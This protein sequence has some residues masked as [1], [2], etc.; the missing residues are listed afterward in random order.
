MSVQSDSFLSAGGLIAGFRFFGKLPFYLHRRVS[1][2]EARA[3]QANRL[4]RRSE[5][6]LHRVRRDVFDHPGSVY[7]ELFRHA[8]CEL[9][10]VEI[11]IRKDGLEDTLARLFRAGVYLT[12]DEYKGR[13]G[14][15]VGGMSRS[16]SV[17][18]IFGH[19]APR[20]IF[21]VPV[22]AAGAVELRF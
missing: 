22:A 5:R 16:K 11:A 12:V 8:G 19:R 14:G 17:L 13:R 7:H 18:S 20:I 9:A 1:L 4:R 3:L 21:P 6:F 10:D 15:P 2:P